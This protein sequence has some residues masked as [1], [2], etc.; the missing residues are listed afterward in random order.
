MTEVNKKWIREQERF[1]GIFDGNVYQEGKF[2]K[3]IP[4]SSI[5]ICY[6]TACGGTNDD[7]SLDSIFPY[8]LNGCILIFRDAS[9]LQSTL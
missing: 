4:L 6:H 5:Q 8:R 9:I 7:E 3:R 1:K 2:Q